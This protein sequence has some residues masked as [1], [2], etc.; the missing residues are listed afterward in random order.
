MPFVDLDE[1]IVAGAG[2]SIAEIF[3][4]DGEGAFRQ[5]EGEF[6]DQATSGGKLVLSTGGGC[7][8]A[9]GNR[10]V[11][12][13]RCTVVWLDLRPEAAA[14]RAGAGGKKSDGRDAQAPAVRPLLADG[15]L[16]ERMQALD[17][18]RRPLYRECADIVIQVEGKTPVAIVEELHAA[19]D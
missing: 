11:L 4:V 15:D 14:T 6:L 9:P 5:L 2:R 10:R 13:E 3:R 16:L 17:A 18:I 8:L 7:V 1:R 19:M 12:R